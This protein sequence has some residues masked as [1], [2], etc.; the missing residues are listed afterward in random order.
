ME[1]ASN[2]E[3][4]IRNFILTEFLP[5]EDPTQLLDSTPMITTGILDSIATLKLVI[6]LEEHFSIVIQPHEVNAEHV[7]T[8][9]LIA[10]LVQSKR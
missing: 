7:D 6:F 9:E 10:K 5:D 4:T 8:I 1:N 3:Q 2:I